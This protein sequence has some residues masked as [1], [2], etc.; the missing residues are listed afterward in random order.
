[1]SRRHAVRTA[2]Q[3]LTE[4]LESRCLLHSSVVNGNTLTI[5]GTAFDDV[6]A[7][8][9]TETSFTVFTK[10]NGI[11]GTPET[12]LYSLINRVVINAGSG[13]DKV[14]A[15]ELKISLQAYGQ[16]GRDTLLGGLA[17]D[18]L[19]GGGSRDIING[20]GG[21]DRLEGSAGPDR[22]IGGGG[23]D[24]VDYSGRA[25]SVTVNMQVD[26]GDGEAGE[27]D[28]V[29]NDIETVIGSNFNDTIIANGKRNY[30]FE[31][32]GGVDILTGGSGNDTL[33]GG[34]GVDSLSG[35]AG[36]DRLIGNDDGTDLLSTDKLDGGSGTD[37]ALARSN[38]EV[39]SCENVTRT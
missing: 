23:N 13:N 20:N 16:G 39:V 15:E 38:D 22:L 17:G 9:S 10:D 31:G 32:R 1:M 18:R 35:N 3:S 37:T 36:N 21:N 6:F 29:S 2:V 8:T 26:G 4:S 11:D 12:Y 7:I 19:V 27:N 34:S 28:T 14:S 5:T 30:R 25:S 24:T 33:I